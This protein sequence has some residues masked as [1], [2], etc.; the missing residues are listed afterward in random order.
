MSQD[1]TPNKPVHLIYLCGAIVLFFL[2]LWT[3]EWIVG[4][5]T[6][7]PNEFFITAG[8]AVVSVGAAVYFYKNENTYTLVNEVSN[9]L[10]KVHW[11]GSKEV[12]M[13]T[14]VVV[15]MTIISA[16]ILGVFDAV[17]AKVTHLIYG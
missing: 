12:K 1:N 4:F 10:K 13:A 17:W 14:I 16:V 6:K 5:F 3:G 11:P 9:E 15:I 2:L 8:A 7:S